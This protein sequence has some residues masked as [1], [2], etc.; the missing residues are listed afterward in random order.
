MKAVVWICRIAVGL[1]FIFSGLI[2]ANDPLGFSYKLQEYFEVFHLMFLNPLALTTAII[3]CAIEMLLGFALLIGTRANAVAWGL[4]LLI[5]FF[6]FLTFYSAFFKVVQTCGCFGDAIPLTPWQSFSKDM[7]LLALVLV[8]FVKRHTIQP[9]FLTHLS[10]ALFAGAV[11]FSF[12]FGLYTY[13]FLPVI[14]FLPYKVGANLLDE[15]KTPPGAKPDEYEITYQ[16]K[17][18][19][20]GAT[21]SMTDKEYMKTGIW[22]DANWQVVGNP[23]SRLVKKGFEPKIRDLAIQDAQG[24]N[25]TQELLGSPFY[26]LVI[27]A[28]DLSH[29]DEQAIARI[30]AL[31]V[32]LTDNYN[33]R[34]VLLTSNSAPDATA[35]AKKHHL[36][37]EVYYADGVPL[38]TIVRAN[39]GILL[40]KGGTVVAKWHY[41]SLPKYDD[42]VKHYLR[43]Q[44]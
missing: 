22:K 32:N 1:L 41:H 29:T 3:L 12:G 21:R 15:M 7:V 27:V 17:N 35:F 11:V 2:K 34:T 42:I 10:N 5:F 4:L 38:K 6:G 30:N 20:T 9:L 31:A 13:N 26:N 28:Y 18:K 14:D 24:T 8:I 44:P 16:L 25:Y 36:I 39:P 40:M 37:S 43:Q 23:E 33:I 19:Q